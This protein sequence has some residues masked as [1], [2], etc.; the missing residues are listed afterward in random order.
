MAYLI[1]PPNLEDST[2]YVESVKWYVLILLWK[3]VGAQGL[4]P[5]FA[6]AKNIKTRS[7]LS[8]DQFQPEQI[9]ASC[10]P[11]QIL[12]YT[13]LNLDLS[14]EWII[15]LPKKA[16]LSLNIYGKCCLCCSSLCLLHKCC[17]LVTTITQYTED[18]FMLGKN[19]LMFSY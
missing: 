15:R 13:L 3:N 14:W 16:E 6:L 9:D 10:P 11:K 7:H 19:V 5:K 2:L 17:V 12:Q 18:F 8:A 4:S 1:L